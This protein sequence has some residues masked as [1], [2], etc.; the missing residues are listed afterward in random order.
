VV[1]FFF[2]AF[3][4]TTIVWTFSGIAIALMT[5][6]NLFGILILHKEMK[7]EVKS[8]WKEYAERYPDEKVP[9]G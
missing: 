8:F 3:T 4:D 6:P 5:I 1:A 7:S 2:A 9:K